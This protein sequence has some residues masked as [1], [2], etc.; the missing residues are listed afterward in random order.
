MPPHMV[1]LDKMN[2]K[3]DLNINKFINVML[4]IFKN[5]MKAKMVIMKNNDWIK[6]CRNIKKL[7]QYT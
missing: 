2:Q 6:Y 3:P 4:K 5:L 7:I 1:D